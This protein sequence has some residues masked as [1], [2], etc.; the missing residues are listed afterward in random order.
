MLPYIAVEIEMKRLAADICKLK[1][2]SAH[3]Q[4]MQGFRLPS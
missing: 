1:L 2:S 4:L 3:G